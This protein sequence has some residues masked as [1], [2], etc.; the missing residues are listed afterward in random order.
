MDQEAP[1]TAEGKGTARSGKLGTQLAMP[2]EV[3]YKSIDEQGKLKNK[4]RYNVVDINAQ[5]NTAN[6]NHL[7]RKRLGPTA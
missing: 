7:L 4:K 2:P 5:G 3:Y 6:I 1:T